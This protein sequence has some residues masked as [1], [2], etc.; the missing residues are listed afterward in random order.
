MGYIVIFNNLA[1]IPNVVLL[2]GPTNV[3]NYTDVRGTNVLTYQRTYIPTYD[4]ATFSPTNVHTY[5][6]TYTHQRTYL[7]KVPTKLDRFAIQKMYSE[8]L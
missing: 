5:Q 4:L 6:R 3:R 8:V 2:M 1:A 7:P